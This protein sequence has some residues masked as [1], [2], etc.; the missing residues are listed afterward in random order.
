MTVASPVEVSGLSREI[1]PH[2]LTSNQI[3]KTSIMDELSLNVVE[4]PLGVENGLKP[5]K[6]GIFDHRHSIQIVDARL[7]VAN[8]LRQRSF[9]TDV[10]DKQASDDDDVNEQKADNG[11]VAD[12]VFNER[13]LTQ[14]VG[15]F[16]VSNEVQS[17]SCVQFYFDCSDSAFATLEF[18]THLVRLQIIEHIKQV[19]ALGYVV[20]CDVRKVGGSHGFRITVQSQYPLCV[21]HSSIEAAVSGLEEFLTALTEETFEQQRS[22]LVTNKLEASLS[23]MKDVA[24]LLWLEIAESSYNFRRIDHEIAAIEK[25]TTDD[26]IKFYRDK[27]SADAIDRRLIIISI[28]PDPILNRLDDP[29]LRHWT[30]DQVDEFRQTATTVRPRR[31]PVDRMDGWFQ[32]VFEA[33][34]NDYQPPS[35]SNFL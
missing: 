30:I 12:V 27:I 11:V 15:I 2:Q 1:D 18:F 26:V 28:G 4:K 31:V 19:M 22:G 16:I 33:K 9:S 25:T 35:F 10:I 20:N 24:N 34:Q 32:K 17:A 6:N 21:V 13:R 14:R 23:R 3:R 5:P 8:L 7:D 29:T